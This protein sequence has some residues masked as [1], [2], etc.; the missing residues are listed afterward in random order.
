MTAA[1]LTQSPKP[2]VTADAPWTVAVSAGVVGVQ[3]F[4]YQPVSSRL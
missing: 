3:L 2:T 4:F 1:V